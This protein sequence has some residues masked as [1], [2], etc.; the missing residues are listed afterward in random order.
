[1]GR[2]PT[3]SSKIDCVSDN[4]WGKRQAEINEKKLAQL[5]QAKNKLA[6]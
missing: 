1:M 6:H 2:F 5:N 3:A 4:R